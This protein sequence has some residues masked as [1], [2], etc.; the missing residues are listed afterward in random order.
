MGLMNARVGTAVPGPSFRGVTNRPRAVARMDSLSTPQ[1][2]QL[3]ERFRQASLVREGQDFRTSTPAR[4]AVET[5]PAGLP[6]SR[7]FADQGGE[8]PR[9]GLPDPKCNRPPEL[10]ADWC[11]KR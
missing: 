11:L 9:I 1:G 6:P 3:G 7:D 8:L 4:I 2:A 10:T 5:A